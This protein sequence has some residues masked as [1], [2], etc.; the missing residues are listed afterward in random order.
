MI[1]IERI[2][3]DMCLPKRATELSAGYDLYACENV[4]I[5][6]VYYGDPD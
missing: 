2:S 6:K 3:E 4:K 5:E 1:K